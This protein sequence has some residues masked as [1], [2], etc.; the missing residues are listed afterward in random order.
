[1]LRLMMWT[2]RGGVFRI[3]SPNIGHALWKRENWC[4]KVVQ[5]S[6]PMEL[7]KILILKTVRRANERLKTMDWNTCK[8]GIERIKVKERR[9]F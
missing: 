9:K 8:V 6:L 4:V 5:R 7:T 2:R 1:M 3:S